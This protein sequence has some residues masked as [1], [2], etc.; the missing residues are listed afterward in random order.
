MCHSGSAPGRSTGARAGSSV[1][2]RADLGAVSGSKSSGHAEAPV[3][4]AA[5]SASGA[6]RVASV[7]GTNSPAM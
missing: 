6:V 3:T 5:A 7:G 1:A 2:A 4:V